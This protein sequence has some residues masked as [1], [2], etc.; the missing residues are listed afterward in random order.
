MSTRFPE[1]TFKAEW[2]DTTKT[3]VQIVHDQNGCRIE[4]VGYP[5]IR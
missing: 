5:T 3:P 4:R 2:I 1:F